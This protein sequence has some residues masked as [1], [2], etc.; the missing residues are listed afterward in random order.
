MVNLNLYLKI[1]GSVSLIVLFAL[2]GSM[3][4]ITATSY[5]LSFV[6]LCFIL[7]ITLLITRWINGTNRKIAIFFESIRNGDAALRYP[8]TMNDP[9]VKDLYAEMN[10]I[11]LLFSQN[12]NEM[13]EKRLYYESILRVLTHEIR[14]SITPIRSLSADLLKYSDTYT[15]EQLREGLEVIHGQAKNL[16]AFLDSYHRLTHLPEP[17]RTE[18]P[19]TSLFRKMERLLCAEAG[20]D[21][22]R[23]SSAADLTVHADQNLI[24]L[25][26]I[27]LIRNA[28]QAIEGQVDGIVSVE[29]LE[30]D[31]R[32]YITITD[33]GPGISPELL[34]A[35]FTPFFSTKSGGSGIGL[36]I[37]HRIMRL[38]GGD[39][40]VNS[41]P[42]VH[43]E[44]R[45]KL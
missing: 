23:F 11:I 18:V 38:H 3:L 28:L 5:F 8:D 42:G 14:N 17:E 2:L 35:I 20:S 39:L 43:T 34:S 30:T 9:F 16:S 19:I 4:L 36:S 32:V 12:Q 1:I 26:L 33:N 44:F 10:R 15:L 31:G 27:N 7:L 6:C 37:S 24:V 13:E 41:L 40:T 29:A 45:M 21:R 22:I 25:A